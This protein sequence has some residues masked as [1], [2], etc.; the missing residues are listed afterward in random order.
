MLSRVRGNSLFDLLTQVA[1]WSEKDQQRHDEWAAKRKVK[2]DELNAG[3]YG[4]MQEEIKRI[5]KEKSAGLSGR[6]P[7]PGESQLPEKTKKWLLRVRGYKSRRG[8]E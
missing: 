5:Q 7:Y 4:Q 1:E 8:E 6:N 3:K 2:E